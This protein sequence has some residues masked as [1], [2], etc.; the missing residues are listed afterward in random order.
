MYLFQDQG[1]RG[2]SLFWSKISRKKSFSEGRDYLCNGGKIGGSIIRA[3]GWKEREKKE[4]ALK[5]SKG[6]F[7]ASYSTLFPCPQTLKASS[8]IP[9]YSPSTHLLGRFPALCDRDSEVG[10]NER[11]K[12][13]PFLASFVGPLNTFPCK[14][15][16]HHMAKSYYFHWLSTSEHYGL[17]IANHTMV[18]IENAS[19][20][21]RN[22][23][24]MG[25]WNSVILTW[26]LPVQHS[27]EGGR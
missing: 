6:K 19:W 4:T 5:L 1:S 23:L 7:S 17:N 13:L 25:H 16:I 15:I 26:Q 12:S 27:N 10:N 3:S 2:S 24:Q 8:S 14:N 9:H 11:G 22:L 18:S 21:P 20:I